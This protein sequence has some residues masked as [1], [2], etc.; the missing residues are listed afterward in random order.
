MA[1]AAGN[2]YSSHLRQGAPLLDCTSQTGSMSTVQ[3]RLIEDV[4]E[5][6]ESY[7]AIQLSNITHQPGTPWYETYHKWGEGCIIPNEL[8]RDFYRRR[9]QGK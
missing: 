1:K 7:D 3:A 8:I 5:A 6:Y 9:A 4:L 2:S